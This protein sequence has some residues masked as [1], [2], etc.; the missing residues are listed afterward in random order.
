[1]NKLRL[2]IIKEK[3]LALESNSFQTFCSKWENFADIYDF[4]LALLITINKINLFLSWH[5]QLV[6]YL[7]GVPGLNEVIPGKSV[8]V[9]RGPVHISF[10]NSTIFCWFGPF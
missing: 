2:L 5:V 7:L 6:V 3:R 10:G 1:M 9:A 8:T 4:K